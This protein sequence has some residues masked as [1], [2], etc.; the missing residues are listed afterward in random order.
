[1]FEYCSEIN[2]VSLSTN[3]YKLLIKVIA[4]QKVMHALTS[5]PSYENI[6]G[7]GTTPFFLF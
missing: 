4:S 1:M 2:K 7:F 5:F 6:A 3:K